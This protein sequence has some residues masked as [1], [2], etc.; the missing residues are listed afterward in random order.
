MATKPEEKPDGAPEW[1]VSFADMIT[2]MMSFFV[3]MFALASGQAAKGKRSRQQQ[4]AVDSLQYRF[5]PHWQPFAS[6]GLM[7]GDSPV[8]NAGRR[9]KQKGPTGLVSKPVGTVKVLRKEQARIRVPGHGDRM[10]IGG[11]VFFDDAGTKLTD[12]QTAWLKVIAEELA[13]KPQEIEVLGHAS[14]RPLPA[15]SSYPD[16]WD[17]AYARCRRTVELLAGLKIDPARLRIGVVRDSAAPPSDA[18]AG[19][20]EDCQVEIYLTDRLPEKYTSTITAP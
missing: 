2:I 1:M 14:P 15:G 19:L 9:E 16:R 13:G 6:W 3:I 10:V 11:I 17:L 20:R 4:A 12:S 18:A 7:P 8:P 5:G